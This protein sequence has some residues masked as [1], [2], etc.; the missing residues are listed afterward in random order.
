VGEEEGVA[1][2]E[3]RSDGCLVDRGLL[4]IGQ[5]DHD[6]VGFFRR[7]VDGHHRKPAS[8]ALA[9]EDEPG[10]K[11]TRTSTPESLRFSAWAWPW[12]PYPMTATLRPASSAGSAS[13]S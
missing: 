6:H 10:R 2:V 5:E 1:V 11:P 4:G 7:L 13:F 12:D 3:V 9:H 8:S